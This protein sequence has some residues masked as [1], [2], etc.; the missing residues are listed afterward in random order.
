MAKIKDKKEKLAEALR[1]NLQK[2]KEQ[3]RARENTTENKKTDDTQK[4]KG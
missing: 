3:A 1:I 4:T 2:R